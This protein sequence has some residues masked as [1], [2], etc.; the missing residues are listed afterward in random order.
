MMG[1]IV[2]F[3]LGTWI[4]ITRRNPLF[5]AI[6]DSRRCF[7]DGGQNRFRPA[8]YAGTRT[9]SHSASRARYP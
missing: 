2:S 9:V 4:H 5:D 6:T 7:P 1:W 8:V 3:P